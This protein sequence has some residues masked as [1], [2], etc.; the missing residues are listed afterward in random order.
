MECLG[1]RSCFI[2]VFSY[3]FC[4]ELQDGVRERMAVN[5]VTPRYVKH[6]GGL[7]EYLTTAADPPH[8][9]GGGALFVMVNHPFTGDV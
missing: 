9:M 3:V 6:R 1:Y 2:L 8:G 4:L 5:L 7:S